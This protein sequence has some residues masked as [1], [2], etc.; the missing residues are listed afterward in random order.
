[1][2]KFS[3]RDLLCP[4][5]YKGTAQV[6]GPFCIDSRKGYKKTAFGHVFVFNYFPELKKYRCMTF[7]FYIV[8]HF[9]GNIY[10]AF[11]MY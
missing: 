6:P 2:A 9:R 3:A 1:M 10:F 4:A 7:Q 11:Y 8:I 5:E